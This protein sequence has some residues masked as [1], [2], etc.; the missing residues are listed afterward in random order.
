[1]KKIVQKFREYLFMKKAVLVLAMLYVLGISAILRADFKY[2][3]D[4]GRVR[5]G[6]RGWNDFSR[7]LNECLSVVLHADAY[8]TDISPLPQLTAVLILAVAGSVVV[9][10]LTG[11]REFCFWNSI[12]VLPIIP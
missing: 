10:V 11:K 7:Y 12:A 4:L 3:D 6:Y 2:I 5:Y 8:L 9:F 1:M